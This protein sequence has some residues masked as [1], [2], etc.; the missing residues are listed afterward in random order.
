[1]NS[2]K[3][4]MPHPTQTPVPLETIHPFRNACLDLRRSIH[5]MSRSPAKERLLFYMDSLISIDLCSYVEEA[6]NLIEHI[7]SI[8]NR[9]SIKP[10]IERQFLYLND[11]FLTICNRAA[12]IV[13]F[14][15]EHP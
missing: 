6:K 12:K 4:E 2:T 10:S 11:T 7:G 3:I 14:R 13:H 15:R 5:R 1:M 9:T 8:M